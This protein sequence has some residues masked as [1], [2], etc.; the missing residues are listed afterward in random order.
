VDSST[1]QSDLPEPDVLQSALPASPLP[2]PQTAETPPKSPKPATHSFHPNA[3]TVADPEATEQHYIRPGTN[4]DGYVVLRTIANTKMSVVVQARQPSTGQ[5]VA[6]K[7]IQHGAFADRESID[8]FQQEIKTL[9][10][11]QPHK[12]IVPIYHVGQHGSELYYV[13]PFLEGGSLSQHLE[14]FQ[15]N[16][17][18]SVSLIEKI[19]RAVHQLHSQEPKILHRDIKPAN[20]LLRSDDEPVLAD[21][22]L[23]KLLDDSHVLTQT[24]KTL[25]TPAYMAPEQT[26]LV[27]T[28][29]SE[30]TDVWALGV[31]LY[32]LL[33][34]VRPFAKTEEEDS[35]KLFWKIVHQEPPTPRNLQ[36]D[37]DAGLAAVVLKCLEK[38]PEDRYGSAAELAEELGRWL[39]GDAVATRPKPVGIR[40]LVRGHPILSSLFG[41]ILLFLPVGALAVW[42]ARQ[43]DRPLWRMRDELSQG[44]GVTLIGEKMTPMWSHRLH[45][46]QARV[47]VDPEGYFT[48]Q[49]SET[50]LIEL[51]R[52]IPVTSYRLNGK[53]RHDTSEFGGKVGIFFG[54]HERVMDWGKYEVY[55]QVTYNDV[56]SNS[57]LKRPANARPVK[58]FVRFSPVLNADF[59]AAKLEDREFALDGVA[60]FQATPFTGKKWRE[61]SV[62]VQPKQIMLQF[63]DQPV[64]TVNLEQKSKELRIDL[65]RWLDNDQNPEYQHLRSCETRFTH[66]GSLGIVISGGSAAFTNFV[67]LPLDGEGK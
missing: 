10:L 23:I 66:Q 54:H 53:I 49:A 16:R 56:I 43:P 51:M 35:A 11:M 52:G 1:K 67:L 47:G 27:P 24:H 26:G 57:E 20:V 19:A 42:Q 63:E 28:A 14:R 12:N 58:N 25:G 7:L 59:G 39:R 64:L 46:E 44:K 29:V 38:R 15:A 13:M 61:L 6:L 8:R 18:E 30:Q 4:I 40:R 17:R 31:V 9:G 48:V 34:G 33:T 65:D 2:T 55:F 32:E 62:I 21:F 45:G 36:P 37:L 3:V 5:L 60:H 41:A 50:A 22:G